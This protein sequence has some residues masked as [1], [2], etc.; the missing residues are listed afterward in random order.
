MPLQVN[1][2]MMSSIHFQPRSRNS[3]GLHSLL[4]STSLYST[5]VCETVPMFTISTIKQ[6]KRYF[7]IC[8]ISSRH[9][10]CEIAAR[11]GNFR[12]LQYLLSIGC[13]WDYNSPSMD[14]PWATICQDIGDNAA[15]CGHW[16]VWQ[17]AFNTGYHRIDE[18]VCEWAAEQGQ[19]HVLQCAEEYLFYGKL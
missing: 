10:L 8:P 11:E 16:H 12:I 18:E 14:R 19:L 13:P 17:Y 5:K 6:A 4:A 3:F 15:E 7:D 2:A 9:I 1:N